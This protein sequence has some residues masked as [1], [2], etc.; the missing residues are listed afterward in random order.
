MKPSFD[1]SKPMVLAGWSEIEGWLPSG[2]TL[3]GIEHTIYKMDGQ[4]D[5][6]SGS[7]I[8]SFIRDGE[9]DVP[10]LY[11]EYFKQLCEELGRMPDIHLDSGFPENEEF[12]RRVT[13]F[14]QLA[15]IQLHV[16]ASW[17]HRYYE[18]VDFALYYYRS[19]DIFSRRYMREQL[20]RDEQKLPTLNKQD[21]KQ[22]GDGDAE[23]VV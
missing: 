16:A 20:A 3:A 13:W 4:P 23:E 5:D 10:Q 21:A 7:F 14:G 1:P 11:R 6:L 15:D 22:V 9:K 8:M 2:L 12:G 18:Y 19:C 17:E